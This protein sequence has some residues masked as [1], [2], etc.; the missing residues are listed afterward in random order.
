MA[1]D[2]V[3]LHN[4]HEVLALLAGFVRVAVHL[5]Y[6]VCNCGGK[7]GHEAAR[8]K[9]IVRRNAGL[10]CIQALAPGD[11]PCGICNF[12]AVEDDCRGLAAKFE[13]DSGVNLRS[14]FRDVRAD[15]RATRKEHVVEGEGEQSVADFGS[16]TL[17]YGDFIL[18]E[19][20]C[21]K[22]FKKCAHTGRLVARFRDN[23][24]ACGN[25]RRHRG[26]KQQEGV[27]PRR[28]DEHA[29]L[30]LEVAHAPVQ[31]EHPTP[32][33]GLVLHPVGEVRDVVVDFFEGGVDFGEPGFDSW[34]VEVGPDGIVEFLLAGNYRLAERLQFSN[35]LFRGRLCD[36]P[37]L[38]ALRFEQ[39]V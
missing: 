30:R 7:S 5:L 3:R 23:D 19:N 16:G 39:T 37:A 18:L 9:H 1:F 21:D 31:R 4:M 24:V 27:V 36:L 33:A 29:A 15:L 20:A 28:H 13:R 26:D 17:H 12:H 10:A 32:T 22:R 11:F 34:L 38:F 6:V 25:G 14:A 8:A 2:G 35:T